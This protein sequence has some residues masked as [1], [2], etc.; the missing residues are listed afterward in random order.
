M[1]IAILLRG[2]SFCESYFNNNIKKNISINYKNSIDNYKEYLFENNDV[3]I[4]FHTYN[5]PNL[6]VTELVK[7]YNPKSFSITPYMNQDDAKEKYNSCLISCITVINL[8]LSYIA[9]H[10]IEYDYIILTR[11]DLNFKV[12]LSDLQLTKKKFMITCMTESPMSSD[13]NFYVMDI[14]NLKKFLYIL[15]RS[16]PK[17]GLHHEFQNIVSTI[18][19]NNIVL[20]FDTPH[21]I[22]KGTPLYD[23]VRAS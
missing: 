21:V 19:Q 2:I 3:D 14:D 16:Q 17:C 10:N 5:N 4:F 15:V 8:F 11:F 23:I 9:Q 7:D 1:K 6:N 22:C 12:K 18:G 13:D 20:L